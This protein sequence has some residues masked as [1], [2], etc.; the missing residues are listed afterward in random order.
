MIRQAGASAIAAPKRIPVPVL[1]P[2]Y[3][4]KR[5]IGMPEQTW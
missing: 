1:C 2:F 4:I 3:I 5:M